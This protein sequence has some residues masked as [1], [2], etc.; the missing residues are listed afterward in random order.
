LEPLFG[1]VFLCLNKRKKVFDSVKESGYTVGMSTPTLSPRAAAIAAGARTYETGQPCKKGHIAPRATLNSTCT[2]CTDAA[3]KQ[4][5]AQRPGKAA[6]YTAKFRAKF[7][8][9]VLEADRLLKAKKREQQPEHMK[10]LRMKS[11]NKRTLEKTG[12]EVRPMNRT[13]VAELAARLAA[14]HG[15]A[16]TYV[17]GFEKQ[18]QPATFRCTEHGVE[19][20]AL[21]H[22]VLRGANSC[23]KCGHMKSAGEDAVHRFISNLAPAEQRNRSVLRPKELDIYLPEHKLAIEYCGEFWHSARSQDDER[24]G[25]RKHSEKHAACQAQG[26]R[27]ITLWETEWK[28]HNYAVRRLLRNAVGKSKGKLMAR[29]CELRKATHEEAKNFYNRYH[30]QG[31][32]GAG[33]HYALFWKGKMVACMRFVLGANDR[34]AAAK[35]RVWTLGRYATRVTVAGA[36][37]RLFKAFVDD[38]KPP[39]VKSFSDNRFFDGGMYEQLG[40][41]ME[42]AVAPDYAVWSPVLGLRPKSHYQRRQISKRLKDHGF[43]EAFD[44]TSDPRTEAEMIYHMGCGKLFDCGKKRWVWTAP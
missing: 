26:V 4:W 28:L 44:P 22:N 42:E 31:G 36:A 18:T 24:Q 6:E 2:A 19:F 23:P 14:V 32:A 35:E 41:V 34:G 21:P 10:A 1:G 38:V 25:R 5:K 33:E 43:D 15:G 8:E 16:M 30:P 7:R 20:A 27:L 12:R 37:S 39:T 17:A 3:S 40:F 9:R 11:Y 29:K 13:P